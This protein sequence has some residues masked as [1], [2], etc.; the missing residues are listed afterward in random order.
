MFQTFLPIGRMQQYEDELCD[1]VTGIRR[2]IHEVVGVRE[3]DQEVITIMQ[4]EIVLYAERTG[5]LR[6]LSFPLWSKFRDLWRLDGSKGDSSSNRST[7]RSSDDG[8]ET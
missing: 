3:R 6:K 2:L 4:Q 5:K 8:R 1:P 7:L